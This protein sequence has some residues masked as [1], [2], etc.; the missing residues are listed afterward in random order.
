MSSSDKI[1]CRVYSSV[2]INGSLSIKNSAVMRFE[3]LLILLFSLLL[4]GCFQQQTKPDEGAKTYKVSP[5]KHYPPVK[6]IHQDPSAVLE[7]LLSKGLGDIQFSY[8]PL[9]QNLPKETDVWRRIPKGFSLL[10]G[11]EQ[12]HFA[13]SLNRFDHAQRYFDTLGEKAKPYLHHIVEEIEKRGMPMEIALLPA[14]ESNFVPQAVSPYSAVGLWQFIPSTGRL[15]GLKQNAWYDGRRDVFASTDAALDYLQTL[16]DSLD[17]DWLHAIA[18]YNCGEG[19]VRKAI[20]KNQAKGLPTDY[21]SLPLP[22]ET[23]KYIPSLMALSAVVQNPDAYGVDLPKIDNEPYLVSVPTEGQVDLRKVAKAAGLEQSE[24]KK[25]NPGFKHWV[26]D[27]K[28][29]HNLLLPLENANI[30]RQGQTEEDIYVSISKPPYS[31]KAKE[32]SKKTSYAGKTRQHYISRGDSLSNLAKRYGVSVRD[33]CRANGITTKTT[34][35]L[36]KRLIIPAKTRTSR[37][38]KKEAKKVVEKKEKKHTIRKGD[39]LASLAK[40]YKISIEALCR[41]NRISK[42]TIL[43]IGKVLKIPYL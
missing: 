3:L 2:G 38:A 16:H 15:F 1:L 18:A 27:P 43:N 4:G 11:I 36:G 22:S 33:I 12:Q 6:P 26:T 14:I 20:A 5:R 39:T 40:R 19:C 13:R 24:L 41:L 10:E 21:W 30:F 29:P 9:P 7:N 42:K 28:G 17:N 31:A 32:K 8:S 25:L 35:D 23:K 34:L 37:L